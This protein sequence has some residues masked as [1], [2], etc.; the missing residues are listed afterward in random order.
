MP[1]GDRT[2]PMGMGAKTGRAAGYCGGFGMPGY[3]NPAPGMGAG[4]GFGRNPGARGRGY[5]G[6]RRGWRNMFFATGIPGWGRFGGYDAAYGYP[7]ATYQTVDPDVEKQ[8]LRRQAELL[9]SELD[10]IKKRLAEV[11]AGKSA[12]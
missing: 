7:P 5:G 9:E 10:A 6:G 3:A 11:E 4:M 1:R 2:G 12:D 8:S